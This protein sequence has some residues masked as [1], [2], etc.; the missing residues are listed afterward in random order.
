MIKKG[1]IVKILP[2]FQDKGDEAFIW[3]A[4]D[5]EEKGRVSISPNIWNSNNPISVIHVNQLETS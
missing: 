2:E 4:I 5:D 1:D 3:T